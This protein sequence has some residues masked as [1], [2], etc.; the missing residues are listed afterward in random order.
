[1]EELTF[2]VASFDPEIAYAAIVESLSAYKRS[3]T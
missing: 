2:S 3:Y 1:M